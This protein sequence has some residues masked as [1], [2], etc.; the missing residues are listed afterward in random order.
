MSNL[1]IYWL[2]LLK[3]ISRN[4][5]E[6]TLFFIAIFLISFF[7]FKIRPAIFISRTIS[8]G[9]IGT[10]QKHDLPE[11]ITRLL[12]EPLVSFDKN[13]RVKPNLVTGWEVNNDA[14]KFTFKLKKDLYWNDGSPLRSKDLEFPIP[15]VQASFPD[16]HTIVFDLK[17]S[18]SPFPSL[19]TKPIFKKDT[20][21]GVGK[22][23]VERLD[24]SRVF[25]AKITLSPKQ[26]D[27][28]KVIIR[29]YP[30]EKIA[31][32]AFSIGEIQSL[33]GVSDTSP[34]GGNPQA[35]IKQ[36]VIYNKIVS[37]L[38]NTKDPLL[39]NRSFRQALSYSAPNI[40]GEVEAKTS[41]SPN[42]WAYTTDVNDY[43]SNIKE[44]KEALSRA[45]SSAGNEL[46]KKEITLTTTP[47]FESVGKKVVDS[48]NNMGIKA[49][50]RIE[51]GIP[52]NF[53]ALLIAQSIP[54]DPDQYSLW[55]ST[56]T[57]TN[58]TK[59]STQCCPASARVDKDL[60]DGRRFLKEEERKEKYIDFQKALSE[61]SPATFL[62][63]PKFSVIYLKKIEDNLNKVLEIQ[64][65]N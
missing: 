10:Y 54:E 43:H 11:S 8:E 45:K 53:Q 29:F 42:S 46:L 64:L 59:Y 37:I 36:K 25:I 1:K 7:L 27:L 58:L 14:K 34:L 31:Q 65:P 50:L 16:D 6:L 56:Q 4:K 18:Y 20:L 57:Q 2:I 40:P 15:D 48:W 55:H 32:T 28:P 38:Y 22:Y 44:A 60:E 5:K 21:I 26:A 23:K 62:Y 24:L 39:S 19:L 35:K 63:F 30:N 12:S 41:L 13:G 61:D 49:I 52:Q 33:F 3:Y 51:S 47:Q 17:D 9:I